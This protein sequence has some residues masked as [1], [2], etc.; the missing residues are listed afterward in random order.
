MAYKDYS[1]AYSHIVDAGGH[2]DFL[3]LGS[4]ITAATAGQSIF[5]RPGTYTEN[6]TMKSGVNLSGLNYKSGSGEQTKIKGNLIDNGVVANVTITNICLETN[7]AALLTLTASG[8]TITLN[9]CNINCVNASGMA[10][11]VGA[12]V[13]SSNCGGDLGTTGISYC[14]G[15]GTWR[16]IN[17]YYT[18]SGSSLT[19]TSMSGSMN[20]Q[21]TFFSAPVATNGAGIFSFNTGTVIDTSLI[22]TAAITTAGT[23]GS[24]ISNSLVRSGTASAFSVGSGTTVGVYMTTIISSNAN[25]ITGAGTLQYGNITFAGTSSTINTTTLTGVYSNIGKYVATKQPAFLATSTS[26]QAN[27]TGNGTTYTVQFPTEIYDQDNNFNAVS[28]F[29]APVTGRYLISGVVCVSGWSGSTNGE[30]KI[31]ASN[32]TFIGNSRA[33]NTQLESNAFMHLPFST[34]MDMDS[35]DTVT[36]TVNLGGGTKV[37]DITTANGWTNLGISL[38]C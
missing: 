10:I 37:A 33:I 26:T 5:I 28:T 15:A 9:G 27:V 21:G 24:F 31:A 2:G 17:G 29:T 16:D 12:S 1:V 7:G 18:N 30:L 25:A 32:R 14:S 3:T 36:I 13:Y 34:Y 19:A 11:S 4:A 38:I 20:F 23:G 6:I 8:S 22:N 35:A